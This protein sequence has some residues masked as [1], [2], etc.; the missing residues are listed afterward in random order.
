MNDWGTSDE[1]IFSGSASYRVDIALEA[2]SYAFKVAS[3]DWATINLGAADAAMTEVPLGTT[4]D[5]LLQ[6]SDNNLTVNL[7]E[8]GIYRFAVDGSKSIPPTLQ[9]DRVADSSE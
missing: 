2:N 4:Y 8:D 3:D 1:L 7:A 5:G 6:G 9:V